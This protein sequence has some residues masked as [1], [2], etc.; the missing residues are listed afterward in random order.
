MGAPQQYRLTAPII[1]IHRG[2]LAWNHAKAGKD[3]EEHEKD[4]ETKEGIEYL[5]GLHPLRFYLEGFS[6]Y[7]IGSSPAKEYLKDGEEPI[8]WKLRRLK[9]EELE[10]CKALIEMSRPLVAFRKA[11][12]IGIKGVEGLPG[13]EDLNWGKLKNSDL[14]KLQEMGIPLQWMYD[15]GEAVV[16]ASGDITDFEKKI[17]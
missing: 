1:Y 5:M 13:S 12:C 14:E 8:L 3:I 6:R 16:K 7:D 4:L 15:I 10:D 17:S 9:I 2:D 11:F